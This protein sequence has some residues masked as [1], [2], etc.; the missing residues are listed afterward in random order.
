MNRC[1]I[2]ALVAL[3]LLGCTSAVILRHP[4]G[5]T[6]KCGPYN[7]YGVRAFVAPHQEHQCISDYQR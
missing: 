4:D 7:A 3:S 6:V 2:V 1:L 5:R